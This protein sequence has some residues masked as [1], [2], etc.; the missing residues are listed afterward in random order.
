MLH[1]PESNNNLLT[2]F[3]SIFEIVTFSDLGQSS[4]QVVRYPLL[5]VGSVHFLSD[6]AIVAAGMYRD[7]FVILFHAFV[8]AINK[9]RMEN[10]E[11]FHHISC[12]LF[13]TI[14]P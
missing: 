10:N 1:T 11:L 8:M 12:F 4:M 2:L 5:P 14:R 13:N 9:T 3:L 6:Y 7:G